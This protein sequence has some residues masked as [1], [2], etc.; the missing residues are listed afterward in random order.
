MVTIL[1]RELERKVEK[2]KHMKMEVM[3]P[4]TKNNMNFQPEL[5]H[6]WSV[7]V[8]RWFF[9]VIYE[10]KDWGRGKRGLN[11]GGSLLEREGLIEDLRSCRIL[12]FL[13]SVL[14]FRI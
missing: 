12:T 11:R 9:F 14:F 3:Q 8:N 13:A 1:H 5:K 7:H 10:N 4:K 6:N 2:V